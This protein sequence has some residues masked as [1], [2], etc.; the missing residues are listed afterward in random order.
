MVTLTIFWGG[1]A[2]TLIIFGMAVRTV[3]TELYR[4]N[5]FKAGRKRNYK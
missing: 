4:K 3:Y 2:I 5:K 1:I